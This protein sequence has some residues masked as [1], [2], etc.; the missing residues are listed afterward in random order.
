MAP[1]RTLPYQLKDDGLNIDDRLVGVCEKCLESL[2]KFQQDN[3]LDY[4]DYGDKRLVR[5]SV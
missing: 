1:F 3:A 2:N 4:V 5:V